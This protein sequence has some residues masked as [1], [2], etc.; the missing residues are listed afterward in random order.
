MRADGQIPPECLFD[1][2][3]HGLLVTGVTTA[4]DVDR[5]KRRHQRLLSAI[6]NSLGEL[7]HIAVKIDAPHSR[8]TP[9]GD[10]R[11][12]CSLSKFLAASHETS[13]NRISSRGR[14]CPRLARSAEITFAILAYPPVVC[15]STNRMIGK[16]PAV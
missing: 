1:R 10:S 15:C 2:R 12:S 6:G 5:S 16:P 4:G 11:F 14:S 8:I 9:S 13:S 7:P 3:L